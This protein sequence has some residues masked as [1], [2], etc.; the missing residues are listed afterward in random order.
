MKGVRIHEHG[1]PEVLRWETLPDPPC[2]PQSVRVAIKAASIN[3]LD[4]WVRTGFPG[5]PLPIVLGSDASGV[6]TE[7][8][9]QTTRWRA[10]D[11]VVI[12]PGTSCGKCTACLRRRENLCRKYGILGETEDGCQ[13]EEAV[14][15]ERQ[16]VSKPPSLTFEQAASYSLVFLTAHGMLVR[17]AAAQPGETVLVWGAGSGVGSAAVQIAKVLGCRVIA[18][19]GDDWK[20]EKVKAIGADEVLHHGR[21]QISHRVRELTGRVGAEVIVEHV[22]EATWNESL[23][24]L[25]HGGR[26]V[27][28]GATT[29]P[30]VALDLRHLFMKHQSVLGSSMGDSEGYQEVL[31]WIGAGSVHPVID[32]VFPMSEVAAAHRHI[33]ERR[34]FGKVV[35]KP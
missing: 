16:L 29:G 35:L 19:V 10:G 33:D 8:G 23:R 18:T 4:L 1:G 27:T 17:R 5:I 2:P 32:R 21:E 3:H 31:D 20:I 28:C 6:V 30:R 7:V 11:E 9:A 14:V 12:L 13:R 26:I 22:G 24:C 15:A 25:A 34:Q